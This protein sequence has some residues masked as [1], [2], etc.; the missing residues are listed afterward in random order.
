[1]Y[2]K[3]LWQ[4]KRARR[5]RIKTENAYTAVYECTHILRVRQRIATVERREYRVPPK[6]TGRCRPNLSQYNWTAVVV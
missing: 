5:F 2:V 3:S 6:Y 4:E 1:M